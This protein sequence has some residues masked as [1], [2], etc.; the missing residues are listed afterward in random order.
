[1]SDYICAICKRDLDDAVLNRVGMQCTYCGSRIFYKK[2]P[3]IR[4][5]LLAR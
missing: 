4:K 1:M 3:N 2:R 5:R